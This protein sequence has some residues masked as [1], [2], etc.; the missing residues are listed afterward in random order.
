ML[1]LGLKRTLPGR[2]AVGRHQHRRGTAVTIVAANVHHPKAV[3]APVVA[4]A[5]IESTFT[6]PSHHNR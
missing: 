6:P 4:A 3:P 2:R 1:E 5:I